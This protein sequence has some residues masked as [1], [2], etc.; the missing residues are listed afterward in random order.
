MHI[1][2]LVTKIFER[3]KK[4]LGV[5]RMTPYDVG[6]VKEG[7]E[8]LKPFTTGE[9]LIEKATKTMGR[10]HPQ[11]AANLQEMKEKNFFDLDSRKGKKPGGYNLPMPI[12]RR[13][14]IFMNSAGSYYDVI[15]FLHEAGHAMHSFYAQDVKNIFND[16]PMEI[17]EVAS[18]SMELMGLNSLDEFYKNPEDLK[19]AKLYA[20]EDRTLVILTW[21]P[22]IDSF[23]YWLYKNPDHTVEERDSKFKEILSVYQ[24]WIDYSGYEDVMGRKWQ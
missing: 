21:I 9:E 7:E 16:Y 3:K 23:Q 18:M 5:D 17:A 10:V 1:V 11:F 8:A 4:E 14:F 13:P 22:V 2:P 19:R 20:I 15:V 6:A 24:P 12:S